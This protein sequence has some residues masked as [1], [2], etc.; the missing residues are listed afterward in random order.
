MCPTRWTVRGDAIDDNYTELMDLR[1]WS[2]KAAS[3]REMKARLQAV[4]AVM[5]TFQFLFSCSFG[6][7]TLKQTDSFRQNFTKSVDLSCSLTRNCSSSNRNV[8]KRQIK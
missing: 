7:I 4:K 6:K 8:V 5:S 3:D 1:D 2:L